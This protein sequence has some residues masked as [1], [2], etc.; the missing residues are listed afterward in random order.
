MFYHLFIKKATDEFP[1][2][3]KTFKYLENLKTNSRNTENLCCAC[4][5]IIIIAIVR[6]V[7]FFAVFWYYVY[8]PK[9]VSLCAYDLLLMEHTILIEKCLTLLRVGESNWTLIITIEIVCLNH[10]RVIIKLYTPLF[11]P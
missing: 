2:Y 9:R 5:T 3:Y 4:D 8:H 1:T 6:F 10:T 11:T 7:S